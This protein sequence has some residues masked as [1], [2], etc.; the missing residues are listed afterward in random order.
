MSTEF[1]FVKT[2]I[3]IPS[4]LPDWNLDAWRYLPKQASKPYPVIIMAHGFASNKLMALAPY[5]EAFTSAGYAC[6]VFDYRRWGASDGEPRHILYVT[7]QLEDYRTVIKFCRQQ[8]EFNPKQVI[9]WGTSFSGGHVVTLASEPRLNIAAVIAQC[10][11]LGV[12]S[13]PPLTVVALKTLA[14]ALFDA[15]KQALGLAPFYVPAAAPPGTVGGLTAPGSTEGMQMLGPCPNE[16]SASSILEFLAYAPHAHA[17]LI[18]C[19]VLLVSVVEDNLCDIK[20]V[21]EVGRKCLAVVEIVR[22]NGDHFEVYPGGRLHDASLGAQLAFLRQH[23]EE[24]SR[25]W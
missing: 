23:V 6:V 24:S 5:A 17:E 14:Y 19:P 10:P 11:F 4:C 3:K 9:L 15:L 8:P 25:S 12:F 21:E 2:S 7:E 1:P 22:V 18:R 16:V 20:G 13:S